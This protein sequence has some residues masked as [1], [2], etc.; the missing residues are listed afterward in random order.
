MKRLMLCLIC[1]CALSIYALPLVESEPDR[2]LD[3]ETL[4]N[5]NI[6]IVT[7]NYGHDEDMQLNIGLK[8]IYK[9]SIWISGKKARRDALGRQ[10]YWLTYPPSQTNNVL[11]YEGHPDW[12]PN[13]VAAQDTLTSVGSDGDA[14]LYELLPA[15]NPL[16]TLNPMMGDLY[17]LYNSQDRVL[18]SI[19]GEPAPLPFDPYNS[20]NFCF[21]IPQ[22]G[23]FVT[24]GF[25]THSSY[26]YDYCPFGTPGDRDYGTQSGQS[27]HYP[28]GLAVHQ[29]SY[30]WNLQNH[31]RMLIN[32]YIVHNTNEFD[33]IEDLAISHYVDADIGPSSWG[34][35]LA[36]DDLSGYVKGQGYE[37][38][39]SRDADGDMGFSLYLVGSKLYI[40]EFNENSLH[41]AWYWRVGQ[42][43][44]D[45]NPRTLIPTGRTSNEKYWLAT[46]R[47]P[48][49]SF[50][51]PLRPEQD[52]I[53]EYEQPAPNDTRVLNTYFG[54]QPG[55]P[56]YYDTD[57]EGNFYQRLN[58]APHETKTF[59][60]ILFVGEDLDDLKARS[61]A[62]EA[63]LDAGM[64]IDP[65][66]NLTCLP[67]LA[68]VQPQAPDTF[69]LRW[70]SYTDPDHFEVAY[71]EYGAPASTWNIM[72]FPGSVRTCSIAGFEPTTWYEFKVGSVFY[73]P[74]EVYLETET[75]L[76]NL[77]YSSA[78]EPV[79]V[80]SPRLQN[81]PNPFRDHTRI[82]YELKSP[83]PVAVE[84]YNLRGQKVRSLYQGNA[85]SGINLLSWDGKDEHGKACASGVYYLRV[86]S[87]DLLSNKK[88]L[89]VK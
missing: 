42:G 78:E 11:V 5:G 73:T 86:K 71:K 23:P 81:Y 63:F 41:H 33:T 10:L 22:P 69:N 34:P 32:K 26:Y 25:T 36:V 44:D 51:T 28:L 12:T 48:N 55:T 67:Y 82:E 21:T 75:Q 17:A 84:I 9:S 13:L 37:F 15:Y 3:T 38:A 20:T 8:L 29:E 72:N 62:I 66:A 31:D 6:R 39:Y 49:W 74:N 57:D 83:A 14:D 64:Q 46:G 61:I 53:M 60:T 16:M 52:D 43:P 54:A 27:T 79:A 89:M 80:P 85:P 76:V 50:Y 87:G 68:P 58:L 45:K 77:T 4:N 35:E 59:Y 2:M 88:M 65:N 24:P 40:P 70:Y 47:N 7:T 30:A 18:K 56:G 19:M 1:L